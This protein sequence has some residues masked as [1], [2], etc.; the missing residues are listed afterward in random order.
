MKKKRRKERVNSTFIIIYY[1][2]QIIYLLYCSYVMDNAENTRHRIINGNKRKRKDVKD[3]YG[4]E[5][6]KEARIISRGINKNNN[7][8]Y[9]FRFVNT[10]DISFHYV[11]LP[12]FFG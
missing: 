8:S 4:E 6:L 5:Q 2:F 12:S 1:H 10:K 7:F 3:I 9:C 11:F